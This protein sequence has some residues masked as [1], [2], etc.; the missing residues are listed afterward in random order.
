MTKKLLYKIWIFLTLLTVFS[1]RTEDMVLSENEIPQ[2]NTEYTNKTLWKEDEAFI[3]TVKKVYDE[4]A[5]ENR[6]KN[7]YG[8]IYW[9]YATSMNTYDESYLIAPIL[10]SNKVVAYVEARRIEDRVFFAFTEND[11]KTNDFFNSLIF[12]KRENLKTNENHT[13]NENP[14]EISNSI[15]SSGR[16]LECKT[17]TKTLIVGYLEGGGPNQ[18]GAISETYTQTV[19]K[20]VDSPVPVDTCL[21]DYDAN[22]NCNG[23]G[24]NGGG[25]YNY[26]NPEEEEHED[27]CEKVSEIIS[28]LD[29]KQ[30]YNELNTTSNFNAD[31]EVGFFEKN[32]EFF[33]TNSDSCSYVLK[34][35]TSVQCITGVMHVHPT[36]N[37][38]GD[39]NDRTPSWGDII[40]FLQVPVVQA[41][42]C[43][44]SSKNAY[45]VTITATGSYMV[46][47]NKDTP[48]TNINY[49]FEEGDK[50][51]QDAVQK[52]ED[53]NQYTQQ[54]IENLF[55]EF[56]DTYADID[57]LEIYKL[58]SDKASKLNYNS[59]NKAA[60][61][62]PCP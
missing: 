19:C 20:F 42:N 4:N 35:T 16:T 40:V 59:T 9:D 1:C 10:K 6:M 50:W 3:K 49:N 14:N 7:R 5:D 61:L 58:E 17:V 57:G 44:G 18:G 28:D 45:H 48:P 22:G 13:D 38:K 33:P 11:V 12:T 34:A 15:Q 21:T 24:G 23:G 29:F 43:A 37:C 46:K 52:L 53:N 54:N 55:M 39:Y 27:E 60:S 51:Y 26:P 25:G 62:L 2:Q 47:Y 31:H 41:Q 36:K 30:K 56:M 8:K 32:G